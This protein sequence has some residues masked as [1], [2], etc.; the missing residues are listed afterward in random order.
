MVATQFWLCDVVLFIMLFKVDLSVES[1]YEMPNSD[2]S[3]DDC[4][5]NCSDETSIVDLHR[6]RKRR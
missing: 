2:H 1:V 4:D 5:H 3:N 6:V